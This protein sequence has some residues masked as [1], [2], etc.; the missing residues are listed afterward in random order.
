MCNYSEIEFIFKDFIY[1][2][3]Q[4][5]ERERRWGA[6]GE[7]NSLQSKKPDAGLDPRT[8]R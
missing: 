7:A 5:R 3:E 2:T 4:E 8:M 6:E 1:L